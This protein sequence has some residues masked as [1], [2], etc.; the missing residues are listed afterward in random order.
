MLYSKLNQEYEQL[1]GDSAALKT[2]AAKL[3]MLHKQPISLSN[4]R[5]ALVKV[6]LSQSTPEASQ[7]NFVDDIAR[8][9]TVYANHLKALHWSVLRSASG[10]N[11]VVSDTPV[12]SKAVD[13]LGQTKYGLGA[14]HQGAEWFLPLSPRA[15]L[16][17]GTRARTSI[18]VASHEVRDLNLGQIL[19]MTER[20]YSRSYDAWLDSLVQTWA[21]RY[22]YFVDVYK[23]DAS[24]EPPD[25][26][27]RALLGAGLQ[28]SN[29]SSVWN[30]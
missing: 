5:Q 17:G 24:E 9:T 26:F 10:E 20:I 14:A 4:L 25:E 21:G 8:G 30:V 13:A 28:L 3:S 22:T 15:I 12:I 19:T 18:D 6:S 27:D 7:A 16:R 1:A 11:F 2:Y 23:T 29:K